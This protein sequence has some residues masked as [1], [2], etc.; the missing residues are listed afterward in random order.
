MTPIETKCEILADFYNHYQDNP[1]FEDF[2]AYADLGIPLA[3]MV[4][5]DLCELTE[6][7]LDAVEETWDLFLEA[8]GVEQ[9]TGFENLQDV[10]KKL[11]EINE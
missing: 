6:E 1:E 3:T 7:G 11:G 8:C 5:F 4:M 10:I 2:F 9:D